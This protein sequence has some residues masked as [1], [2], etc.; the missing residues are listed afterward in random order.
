MN[1]YTS[2]SGGGLSSPTGQPRFGYYPIYYIPDLWFDGTDNFVGGST[3]GAPYMEIIDDHHAELVPLAMAITDWSFTS[4]AFAE[5][6]VHVLGDLDNTT[7]SFIRI[8]VVEDNVLHG[9]TTYRHVQRALLPDQALTVSQAGQQQTVTVPFTV[10]AGW[11]PSNLFLIAFVQRDTDRYIFNSTSTHVGP[12]PWIIA[13]EGP[14]LAFIEDGQAVFDA[15]RLYNMGASSDTYEVTVNTDDLPDGWSASLSYQGRKSSGLQFD[16]DGFHMADLSLTIEATTDGSGY[17]TVDFYSQGAGAVLESMGFG[18]LRGAAEILLVSDDN[19]AGHA[20]SVY[21][22]ILAST[23]KSYTIWERNFLPIS[24]ADLLGFEAVIWTTGACTQSLQQSDRDALDVY[25]AGGGRLIMAGENFIHGIAQQGVAP[26]QWFQNKFHINYVTQ[27]SGSFEIV[28]VPDDPVG[29]GL[30]FTLNGGVPDRIAVPSGDPPVAVGC[31]YGNDRPAVMRTD[32]EDF[33]SV[34]MPFGLELV[35]TQDDRDR[36]LKR[37]LEWL[38][39]LSTT[40]APA[41][42][43][44]VTALSPNRPNPFNP[45]TEIAYTIGQPGPVRLEIFNARGQLLRVLVDEAIPA[46]Q[47]TVTWD[48]RTDTGSSA[49]SGTYF[50]RLKTG[51]ELLTRKMSLIK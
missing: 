22:P 46:G 42:P 13:Q 35:P 38:G 27:F 21:Q 5:V 37:S 36:L 2:S 43:T 24:G 19:E 10:S 29:H 49:A 15:I 33:K 41:A 32:R 4:P 50:Y 28:G 25:L 17:V 18:A 34:F 12:H 45:I 1:Y 14:R 23:S 51:G 48:G 16:L 8:A 6:Q 11:N 26:R 9:S 39:V 40:S 3:S 44:A 31:F 20:Y 30:S 7:S 47:H